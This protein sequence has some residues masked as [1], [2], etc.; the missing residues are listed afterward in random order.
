MELQKA[1]VLFAAE[2]APMLV[3]RDKK[4]ASKS[5]KLADVEALLVIS[6][7][8]RDWNRIIA[9]YHRRILRSLNCELI[10]LWSSVEKTVFISRFFNVSLR[11]RA[12]EFVSVYK[13]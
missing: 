7:V 4:Y 12:P 8:C 13:Q 11:V 6:S 9:T 10:H 2:P 3:S 1:V 5:R